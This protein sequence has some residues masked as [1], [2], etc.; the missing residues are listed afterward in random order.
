MSR[1]L[2]AG[3]LVALVGLAL[4]G[5]PAPADPPE[6]KHRVKLSKLNARALQTL[7]RE[8][9]PRRRAQVI[10]E[11]ARSADP[12]LMPVLAYYVAYDPDASVREAASHAVGLI[13]ARAARWTPPAFPRLERDRALISPEYR[14]DRERAEEVYA[15]L[16]R[17]RNARK[18]WQRADAARD[19]A[20]LGSPRVIPALAS[21][22]AYDPDVTVRNVASRAIARLQRQVTNYQP[23]PPPP[24]Q[25]DEVDQPPPPALDNTVQLIQKCAMHYLGRLARPEEV[26]FWVQHFRNGGTYL[27]MLTTGLASGEY[28]QRCGLNPST[29]IT[30]LF[31]D[32]LRRAP[33][34]Y[35]MQV[36][37]G[38][39]NQFRGDRKA[40]VQ[41]WMQTAWP[42]ALQA[43]YPY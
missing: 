35:E 11:L 39:L 5:R 18:P 1:Y 37:L 42:A 24:Y 28:Y 26:N 40:L 7:Q 10:R 23:P 3:N 36:W 21:A 12:S 43:G 6:G 16:D 27:Q 20:R 38:Y 34:V 8:R 32:V 14:A 30:H 41:Q 9:D 13:R 22:A 2:F 29:F 33:S 31:E 19:L 15:N 25:I 17:L 4:A